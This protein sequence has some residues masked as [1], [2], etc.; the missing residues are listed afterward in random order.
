MTVFSCCFALRI[1][2]YSLLN[3]S[4]LFVFICVCLCLSVFILCLSCAYPLFICVYLCL[5]YF[6][7][8][9]FMLCLCCVYPV[10]IWSRSGYTLVVS[11][12][13]YTRTTRPHVTNM[14]TRRLYI[15]RLRSYVEMISC[16]T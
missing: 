7:L 1:V 5:F 4:C 15:S 12:R 10:F 16:I 8:F 3:P 11:D 9:L 2:V 14:V 6:C 13:M